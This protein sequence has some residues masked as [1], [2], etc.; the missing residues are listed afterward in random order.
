MDDRP[1]WIAKGDGDDFE[2]RDD[3][4]DRQSRGIAK[5]GPD[6]HFLAPIAPHNKIIGLMDNFSGRKDRPGPGL[7]LKQTGAAIGHATAIEWPDKDRPPYFE[8]ELAVVIGKRARH[9]AEADAD[10]VILGYT[11]SNDI[12]CLGALQDDTPASLSSRFKLYDDSFP[13]GPFIRTD[14]DPGCAA[15]RSFLNDQ[16]MQSASLDDMAFGVPEVVA[17]VSSV[18]TLNPGDIISMGTPPGFAAMKEGDIVRCEIEGLGSL[19]NRLSF[20]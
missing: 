10:E 19:A 5:V 11:V 7:F 12:T 17:W 15:I 14:F 2:L 4:F 1:V 16:P 9:V 6:T 13:L 18:M 20:R 8:A 3:P